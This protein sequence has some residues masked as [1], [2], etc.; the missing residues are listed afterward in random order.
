MRLHDDLK[1]DKD[2]KNSL[3]SIQSFSVN[4]MLG[5]LSTNTVSHLICMETLTITDSEI[6]SVGLVFF[7]N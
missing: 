4:Q 5:V 1:D 6:L 7:L 3:P 2:L